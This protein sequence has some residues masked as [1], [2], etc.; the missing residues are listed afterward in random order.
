MVSHTRKNKVTSSVRRGIRGA[1]QKI[2]TIRTLT[3]KNCPPGMILR[4]G[5]TRKYSTAVRQ[6]GFSVKRKNDTRY[7]V[8]PKA[9]EMYV[10]SRCIKNVGLP[11][12][13]PALFG[14]LKKGE[15][16]KHGYSF[17]RGESE[18]RAALKKAVDEYGT[19]GVFRKLNAVEKLTK[20]ASPA[21]SAVF[22][23]DRNWIR[24]AFG[25]L[26]N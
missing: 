24:S 9:S 23:K 4:K 11:G 6:R 12:K 1:L 16:A 15:L 17:R 25:G 3:R 14:P 7:H 21:A 5:Y 22:R 8:V 18:R 20:R 2:P 10:E 26:K 19:L 13:G